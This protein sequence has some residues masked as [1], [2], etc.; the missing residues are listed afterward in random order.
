MAIESR[1]TFFLSQNII[2]VSP[3][4]NSSYDYGFFK[5][6]IV[7]PLFI[8]CC[9]RAMS[10]QRNMCT[11][12]TLLS[13]QQ[14]EPCAAFLRTTRRRMVW[15]YHQLYENLWVESPSYLQEQ[16]GHW[17]QREETEGLVCYFTWLWLR[18]TRKI[19]KTL[20]LLSASPPF[21]PHKKGAKMNGRKQHEIIMFWWIVQE[22][23][24]QPLWLMS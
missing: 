24:N 16:T 19:T 17:S 8:L 6:M 10:K 1:L 3:A 13:Q 7:L 9:C 11:Y 15:R 23:E 4:I 21:R 22:L 14:R 5:C 20:M 12:W 2:L 18:I